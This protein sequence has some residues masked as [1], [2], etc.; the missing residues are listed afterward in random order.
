MYKTSTPDN[1]DQLVFF[2][3]QGVPMLG[4]QESSKSKQSSK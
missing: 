1:H 3:I 4:V 2:S